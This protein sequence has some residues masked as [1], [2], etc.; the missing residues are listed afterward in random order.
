MFSKVKL[1]ILLIKPVLNR[2][3]E[4]KKEKKDINVAKTMT[5][6]MFKVY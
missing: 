6:E 3:D 2:F 4:K 1:Q 5:T